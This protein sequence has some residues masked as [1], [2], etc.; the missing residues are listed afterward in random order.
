[1]DDNQSLICSQNC[2][3][4]L[5]ILL[6]ER[7]N[8]VTTSPSTSNF[9]VTSLQYFCSELAGVLTL[10]FPNGQVISVSMYHL[11]N[12]ISFVRRSWQKCLVRVKIAS[13]FLCFTSG[14]IKVRLLSFSFA[15]SWSWRRSTAWAQPTESLLKTCDYGWSRLI[16]LD[17]RL[18]IVDQLLGQPWSSNDA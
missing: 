14:N 8:G 11:S 12:C 17:P 13:Y 18:I 2:K 1:M 3:P 9:P 4:F 7:K 16:K 5:V 15:R 6:S 10:G